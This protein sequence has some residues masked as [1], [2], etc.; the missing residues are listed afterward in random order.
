MLAQ[1][2][3]TAVSSKGKGKG[4]ANG[5]AVE[6]DGRPLLTRVL[7]SGTSLH[8]LSDWRLIFRRS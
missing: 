5:A 6:D 8:L 2:D 4:K 7:V 3:H 1:E